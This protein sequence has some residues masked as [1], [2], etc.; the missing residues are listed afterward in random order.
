VSDSRR[1][2]LSLLA[3]H[4]GESTSFSMLAPGLDHWFD[5]G[6]AEEEACVAYL[7]TGSAWVAATAPV[8]PAPRVAKAAQKFV[9]AAA[10]RGRRACFF[11]VN[12]EFTR[13]AELPALHIGDQPVWDPRRWEE[14]LR[15]NRRLRF[16]LRAARKAGVEVRALAAE[17]A[18]DPRGATRRAVEKLVA[19]WLSARPMAPLGFVSEVLPFN[20]AEAKRYWVALRAGRLEGFL[21]AAPSYAR[22]GWFLEHALRDPAAPNGTLDL[23]VHEAMTW[24]AGAGCR[25]ATFGLAPLRAPRDFWLRLVRALS[26]PL[27]DFEGL[28]VF[29][30]RFSP[31]A[32]EKVFLAY[33]RSGHPAR[34]IYDALSAFAQ[35][36]LWRFGARTLVRA[37]GRRVGGGPSTAGPLGGAHDEPQN[38]LRW[39]EQLQARGL[40]SL[41]ELFGSE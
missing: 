2:A 32:W 6:G 41:R 19:R 5:G 13:S 4:G 9:A 40:A 21:A 16:Q 11:D 20:F 22:G 23:L 29:K 18:A 17:E 12:E 31:A 26:R 15:R 30:S 35:G 38:P 1:R 33:P 8:G 7:D 14:A 10:L 25:F 3:R 24:M 37:A 28:R 34:A 36:S 39:A 27:Y